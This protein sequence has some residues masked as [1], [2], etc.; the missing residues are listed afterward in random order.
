MKTI[1]FVRFR[2]LTGAHIYKEALALKKAGKYKLIIVAKIDNRKM[3]EEVFDEIIDLRSSQEKRLIQEMGQK[4]N[5]QK[6]HYRLKQVVNL[7][8]KGPIKKIVKANEK[9]RLARIIKKLSKRVDAFHTVTG[10]DDVPYI[11]MKNTDKP[12]V[13]DGGDFTGISKGIK[14]LTKKERQMER[15][16]FEHAS[17]IIHKGPPFEIDYYR[18]LGYKIN[19]PILH[20]LDYCDQNLFA[21]KDIQK[22]SSKDKEVHLVYCGS[23]SET[24]K[25]LSNYYIPL[26]K[27]FTQQ[28]IH[29]HIYPNPGQWKR[30][31]FKEYFALDK[32]EKYFHFHKPLPYKKLPQE[33]A[34]YDYSAWIHPLGN[35]SRSGIGREKYKVAI[36]NKLFTY[37]EAG[38]PVI[39]S[40][41]LEYGKAL[42]EK[43]K[44]GVSIKDRDLDKLSQVLKKQDYPRLRKNVLE[45]R[46]DLSLQN[47]YGKLAKFYQKILN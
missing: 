34:Q 26:G 39:I 1:A 16:C 8:Y 21:P 6:H 47:Q 17:G 4:E 25:Y 11:V 29:L 14:R 45:K 7:F 33:I 42:I 12:V 27:I 37:L 30:G 9:K 23:I 22:L 46:E 44:I 24:N 35:Y 2:T 20:W 41:H 19:C 5:A 31:I 15:Y 43:Y 32:K 28:K 3:L 36:G 10:T 13:F 40:H 18:K 38:L